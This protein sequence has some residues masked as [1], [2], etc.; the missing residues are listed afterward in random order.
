[1][2]QTAVDYFKAP[3]HCPA[4]GGQVTLEG[5]FL[6]CRNRSCPVQ[7]T[8]SIKVWIKRLGLLHWGDSLVE[9][10]TNPNSPKVNSIADLY[11]LTPEEIA[12]CCSGL[13]VAKKCH[14]TLHANKNITL[15]L[16]IASLNIPNLAVATATDIVQAGF[17]DVE[18]ILSLTYEN[19]LKV[20][21]IGEITARQVLDG[22]QERKHAIM[23]LAEVLEIKRPTSGPLSGKSFCITGATSKPRKAVEKMI[24]DAGGIVKSSV[25]SG[26][27]YLITNDP[28]TGSSKMQKAK[29][30]GVTIITENDLYSMM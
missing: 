26:L 10:L 22:L 21:N 4:C 18:K 7:L 19:L 24:M 3:D 14:E 28:D 29:K 12:E 2:T 13:K 5:D 8:G 9:M 15:E 6:Y 17:D 25:G 23:E 27:S 1:M 16:M 20:P 30:N 11:R